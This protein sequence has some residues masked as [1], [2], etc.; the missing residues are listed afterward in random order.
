MKLIKIALTLLL[1]TGV[2]LTAEKPGNAQDCRKNN[3][4]KNAQVEAYKLIFAAATE[5][6]IYEGLPHPDEERELLESELKRNDILS[7]PPLDGAF[8]TPAIKVVD[9]V[10]LLN[11]LSGPDGIRVYSPNKCG[12]HSD[13]CIEFKHKNLTYRAFVCFGCRELLVMQGESGVT[14]AI[15]DEELKKLLSI[16]DKKRPKRAMIE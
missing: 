2:A 7:L 14:F 15:N 4:E 5:V 10:D 3:T 12:F 9:S 8:Y 16:Y 6:I 1:L 11:Y 13:Y